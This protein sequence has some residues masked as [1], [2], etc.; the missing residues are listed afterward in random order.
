MAKERGERVENDDEIDNNEKIGW[1]IAISKAESP[2]EIFNKWIR[3]F[4]FLKYQFLAL[5]I[6]D[7]N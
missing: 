2:P 5:Y 6:D 4:L 3:F 1:N 7:N